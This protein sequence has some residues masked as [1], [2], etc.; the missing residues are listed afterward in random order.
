MFYTQTDLF[1]VYFSLAFFPDGRVFFYMGINDWEDR[2][3]IMEK[4]EHLNR[5]ATDIYKSHQ[6]LVRIGKKCVL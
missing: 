5:M 1:S 3:D 4:R 6:E 2:P